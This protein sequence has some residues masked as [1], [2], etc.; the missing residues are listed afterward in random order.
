MPTTE[1]LAE[2]IWDNDPDYKRDH[3]RWHS[4]GHHIASKSLDVAALMENAHECLEL[5][6]CEQCLLGISWEEWEA[7]QNDPQ[8]IIA[9]AKVLWRNL[10]EYGRFAFANEPSWQQAVKQYLENNAQE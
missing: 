2:L 4:S 9:M 5:T 8:M 1:E 7:L 6:D 3:L 10:K